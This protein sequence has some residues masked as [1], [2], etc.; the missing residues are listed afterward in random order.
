[1]K[2]EP[3]EIL[4]GFIETCFDGWTSKHYKDAINKLIAEGIPE[5]TILF[6]G[7]DPVQ[8]VFTKQEKKN[9][10]ALEVVF[11][12]LDHCEVLAKIYEAEIMT[13]NNIPFDGDNLKTRHRK[14]LRQI[15]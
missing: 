2:N 11:D 10:E 14:F 15:A 4:M 12:L 7:K 13:K 8:P 1:M 6:E 9:I 3:K 5:G